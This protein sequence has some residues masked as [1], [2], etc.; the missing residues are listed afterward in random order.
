MQFY[1]L[2]KKIPESSEMGKFLLW[3]QERLKR[4]TK[5]AALP[6]TPGLLLD[7]TRS[8]TDLIVENAMMRQPTTDCAESA[9]QA[10]AT[11]QDR[12]FLS[13]CS[14]LLYEVLEADP[15]HRSA[16]YPVALAS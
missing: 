3:L 1:S 12:P 4:W 11:H 6:L 5:P 9:D 10:T 14:T 13:C 8:H 15:S 16:R 7:I 2:L